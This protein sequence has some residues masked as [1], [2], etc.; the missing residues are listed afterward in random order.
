MKWVFISRMASRLKA[1]AIFILVFSGALMFDC[2]NP[3]TIN[4]A[5]WILYT[6][7]LVPIGMAVWLFFSF[8]LHVSLF[9]STPIHWIAMNDIMPN[10]QTIVF[11]QALIVFVC[12]FA[13]QLALAGIIAGA[14]VINYSA[15]WDLFTFLFP[16]Y[17]IHFLLWAWMIGLST[18][19]VYAY[20]SP[21][22]AMLLV[23]VFVLWII[24][25]FSLE[26][27]NPSFS[28]WVNHRWPYID[29][30]FSLTFQKERMLIKLAY[31]LSSI[32]VYG[33]FRSMRRSFAGLAASAIFLT[34]ATSFLQHAQ[35]KFQLD[36]I[37][38]A[39]D[40][41]L[42]QQ[43]KHQDQT[44][45]IPLNGYWKIKEI[46]VNPKST[47]PIKVTLSLHPKERTVHFSINEQFQIDHIQGGGKRLPFQQQG[48][49]VQVETN[50][51]PSMTIY[52]RHTFG[53]TF[54]PLTSGVTLLPFEANWYPQPVDSKLYYIDS[55]GTLHSN[56]ETTTCTRVKMIVGKEKYRWRG[57]HPLCLSMINGPY[58]QIQV[59]HTRFLVYKPFLTTARN[60]MEL[61]RQL[62]S[63]RNEL[64]HVFPDLANIDYCTKEV[65]SVSIIPKSINTTNLSL[66]DST[67]ADGNYTFYI[68]PFLDVNGSPATK[69]IQE[70]A[71]FFIPYRL[72]ENE[73]IGLFAGLYLMEKLHIPSIGYGNRIAEKSSIDSTAREHYMALS[74]KEKENI[75]IQLV[76]ERGRG[77]K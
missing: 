32:A 31:I 54:Y 76:Q 72:F 23:G 6:K 27:R 46:E 49:V 67:V 3:H 5:E 64:C 50:G 16:L 7:Y 2:L 37:L 53:S 65:K 38:L 35:S 14:V 45:N 51:A 70:L 11:C 73:R 58:K 57:D 43:I 9:T 18:S 71:A 17:L 69:H 13:W 25:L 34:V 44:K 4:P 60:Y 55:S 63:I 28:L 56:V 42:Y 12:F 47:Y 8:R 77:D 48:N 15:G 74:M 30:L 68:D 75:L 59:Q 62:V 39:N 1:E 61:K 40:V 22:K 21:K 19:A 36:D 66:Y 10:P 33:V 24:V 20:H 52:Y 29:P 41:K 26:Y